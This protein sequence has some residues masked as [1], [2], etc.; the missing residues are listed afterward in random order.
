MRLRFAQSFV[1]LLCL[2]FGVYLHAS[3]LESWHECA[4]A[5][6]H[7]VRLAGWRAATQVAKKVIVFEGEEYHIPEALLNVAEGVKE[8][9]VMSKKAKADFLTRMDQ[10]FREQDHIVWEVMPHNWV[11]DFNNRMRV[12]MQETDAKRK[13]AFPFEEADEVAVVVHQNTRFQENTGL[14][15]EHRLPGI[16]TVSLIARQFPLT[17]AKLIQQSS[18]LQWSGGG[19][20][21][22]PEHATK[23]HLFGGFCN[24][25]LSDAIGSII[26]STLG[27][28]AQKP[29]DIYVHSGFSYEFNEQGT[30]IETLSSL[31][32]EKKN[33]SLQDALSIEK[34]LGL[35]NPELT[36]TND[37]SPYGDSYTFTTERPKGSGNIFRVHILPQ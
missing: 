1:A 5:L 34:T 13:D 28:T 22:V 10:S 19:S 23:F 24:A 20:F 7:D 21:E 4:L 11:K 9:A 15:L 36:K 35:G 17:S 30:R 37:S 18:R 29:K 2:V 25:C 14:F 12:A 32:A 6:R 8:D 27:K 26:E 16:P 3:T 33:F 31:L